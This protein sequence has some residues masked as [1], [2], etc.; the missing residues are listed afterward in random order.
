MIV[1]HT[2][3]PLPSHGWKTLPGGEKA[4]LDANIRLHRRGRLHAKLI[5]FRG[6][7]DLQRFWR[8]AIDS[9]IGRGAYGVCHA[10]VSKHENFSNGRT[11]STW[12][13]VDPH[14]F[15]IIGLSLRECGIEAICHESTHAA[16][17]YALRRGRRSDWHFHDELPEET[18]CYPAGKIARAINQL[19]HD[20][21]L[22]ELR[23][24]LQRRR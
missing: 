24:K 7:R 20:E 9:P 19:F 18:I 21:G 3:Q 13:E 14:Y 11:A 6:K 15:A 1:R 10:L 5:V 16:F 17:A 4:L 8:D 2:R 22:W 23:D 12:I